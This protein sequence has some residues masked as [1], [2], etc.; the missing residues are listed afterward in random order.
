MKFRLYPYFIALS[1]IIFIY[2]EVFDSISFEEF[3]QV[4]FFILFI[5]AS[6]HFILHFLIQDPEIQTFIL[7]GVVLFLFS[8][9]DFFY[10][11]TLIFL[12]CS[13]LIFFFFKLLKI[14]INKF[15]FIFILNILPIFIILLSVYLILPYMTTLKNLSSHQQSISTIRQ[16]LPRDSNPP[17]NELPDIYLIILDGYGRADVLEKYYGY[18]N[19]EF[20]QFLKSNGFFVPSASKSNYPRTIFSLFTLFNMQYIQQSAPHIRGRTPWQFITPFIEEGHLQA[21]LKDLG[22][23][24]IRV[25]NNWVIEQNMQSD[26]T[27][28]PKPFNLS[29]F[30]GH[31]IYST[32]LR[33]LDPLL[34]KIALVPTMNSHRQTIYQTF[35]ILEKIPQTSYP[36]PKFVFAHILAP[37]PPFVFYADGSPRDPGYHFTLADAN[38]FPHTR[39]QYRSNYV[40]QLQY[41]NTR[42][43]SVINSILTY[44]SRDTIIILTGDHGP[45]MLYNFQ[46]LQESCIHE[47]FSIFMA[48]Y[49]PEQN[50]PSI[51]EDITLVNLFPLIMNSYFHTNWP[52]SENKQ[53]FIKADTYE[54]VTDLTN[55]ACT[56]P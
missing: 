55:K 1:S 37:H 18:S 52:L 42:L 22:Y 56:I 14:S 34:S 2:L 19:K 25:E 43:K 24:Q 36:S 11:F 3:F 28:A 48:I 13:F 46:S 30:L 21:T 35:D 29:G 5:L 47:R 32:P 20:V 8:S 54:D 49:L 44:S 41:I 23:T 4:A 16:P 38:D 15:H 45:G 12:I 39:E 17:L 27:L 53:F 33:L 7:L 26:I 10:Y 31:I 9:P 50:R 6:I 51:P 40:E